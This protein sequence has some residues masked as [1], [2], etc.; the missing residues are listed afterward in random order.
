[1]AVKAP[2]GLKWQLETTSGACD[3]ALQEWQ[4]VAEELRL[5][6]LFLYPSLGPFQQVEEDAGINSV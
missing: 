4:R 1:M 3:H 5:L 2:K 6:E